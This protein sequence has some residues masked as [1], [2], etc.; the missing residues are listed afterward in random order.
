MSFHGKIP[1]VL[2]LLKAVTARLEDA[3]KIRQRIDGFRHVHETTSQTL[4][5]LI[6]FAMKVTCDRCR[7]TGESI[8]G[9]RCGNCHRGVVAHDP[10]LAEK[11][12]TE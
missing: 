10:T 7:G 12:L 9:G 11:V 5:R 8:L 4:E 2:E 6:R 1:D 3:E